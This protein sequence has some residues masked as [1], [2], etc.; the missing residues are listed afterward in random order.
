MPEQH[1]GFYESLPFIFAGHSDK[2]GWP[3]AS[4]LTGSPGF[5]KSTHSSTLELHARPFPGNPLSES[6]KRRYRHWLIGHRV[7]N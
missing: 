3:W 5:I 2:E 7:R 6:L 4:I 1:I